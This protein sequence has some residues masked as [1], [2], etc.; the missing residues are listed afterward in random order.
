MILKKQFI[1]LVMVPVLAVIVCACGKE[2]EIRKESSAETAVGALS[3]EQADSG[4]EDAQWEKG[5]NLPVDDKER[6]EAEDDCKRM[7]EIIYDIFEHAEKGEASNVTLSEE[8][9]LKMQDKIEET[10]YPV[11]TALMYSSMGNYEKADD[12]LKRCEEGESGSVIVY[13]IHF[14]GGIARRKYIFDG[15]DMYIL[16][17][18]GVWNRKEIPGMEYISYTRIKEWKY[19]EKGWFGYEMCVPE[20]PEVTEIVDGSCLVRIKPI[21]GENREMSERCVRFIGYKGNNLLC[22]DWDA[23]HMENLDYNGLYESLYQMKYQEKFSSENY[24]DGIPP[25]EFENLIMEYLP[26]TA[27]QIREY[28]V[29]DE[30]SGK[31]AWAQMGCLNYIPN[32]FGTSVPEVTDIRE[33]G[34]G[35]VTLTVDALCDMVICND[36]VITHELTVKFAEDGSFQYLGNLVQDN[37]IQEIPEYQYRVGSR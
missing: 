1:L 27:E 26:V 12:F 34:D 30:E 32:F 5:Y 17:A 19:T 24:P 28:A 13:E 37:G 36:A 7:M 10:G 35:T 23:G 6:K 20:P 11:Y 2:K 25:E 18:R 31:Y 3:E 15:T 8:T 14:D 21:S 9:I 29:M 4:N 33:N 22:S 16:S